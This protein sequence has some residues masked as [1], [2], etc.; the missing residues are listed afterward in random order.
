MSVDQ[1][2]LILTASEPPG[3]SR[4]LQDLTRRHRGRRRGQGM[5]AFRRRE[6]RVANTEG[7]KGS[8]ARLRE[9]ALWQEAESHNLGMKLC[10][11]LYAFA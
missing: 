10:R 5:T 3:M 7:G 8:I 2:I 6:F 9:L 11:T 4:L 1:P